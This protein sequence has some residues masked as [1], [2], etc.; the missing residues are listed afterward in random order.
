[1]KVL[2]LLAVV[3]SVVI[4]IVLVVGNIVMNGIGLLLGAITSK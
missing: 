2:K 4:A 3:G 1:M